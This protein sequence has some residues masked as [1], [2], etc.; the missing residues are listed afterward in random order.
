MRF[1]PLSIALSVLLL[2]AAP[3]G[4]AAETLAD[5]QQ[6]EF[7]LQKAA[8]REA[9]EPLTPPFL[10]T[11]LFRYSRHPNYFCEISLWWVI[12]AF[13]VSAGAP[14]WNV[15]IL[16]AVVLTLLFQGSTQMTE[17]ITLSKYPAYA[18][19]QRRTSRLIP[20]PPRAA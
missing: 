12:Y 18:D 1:R 14:L 17:Q 19:Y 3:T 4:W 9:G 10:T 5:Q 13:S 6:W 8:A 7:H 20:M 16:G 2:S 11:G 15:T